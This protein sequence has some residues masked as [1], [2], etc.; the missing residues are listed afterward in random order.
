M[1]KQI[2]LSLILL[3]TIGCQEVLGSWQ[4][5][6][7]IG[8]FM[9]P[10][11]MVY[12]RAP[13]VEFDLAYQGFDINKNQV[14]LSSLVFGKPVVQ[15]KDVFL[16]SNLAAQPGITNAN[17]NEYLS[18]LSTMTIDMSLE[19]KA[20]I[21]DVEASLTFALG[22]SDVL[23]TMG[24]TAPVEYYEQDITTKYLSGG[25]L[26]LASAETIA[27]PTNPGFF[28]AND[29]NM[30]TFFQQN[31]LAPKGLT[32]PA[33]QQSLGIG[34]VR[35]YAMLDFSNYWPE[36]VEKLQGGFV[37]HINPL[38]RVNPNV[39]WPIERGLGATYL[40]GFAQCSLNVTPFLKPF[41]V[42]EVTDDFSHD[43]LMRVPMQ[44]SVTNAQIVA[45]GALTFPA[46]GVLASANFATYD[47]LAPFTQF[48][49]T[50]PFFAD[51]TLLVSRRRGS[52]GQVM[53]GNRFEFGDA[54]ELAIWYEHDHKTNDHIKRSTGNNANTATASNVYNFVP[55][56]QNSRASYQVIGWCIQYTLDN[57]IKF[58]LGSKH[59]VKGK[60]AFQYQ[61]GF[62]KAEFEF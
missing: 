52:W 16:A 43:Q 8:V 22:K 49:T 39:V 37:A 24:I 36:V 5:M 10:T 40:G 41:I 12:V 14:S 9:D 13:Y 15:L 51:T 29:A 59:V 35:V 23:F 28:A 19:Q 42:G 30:D 46:A 48:D 47:V 45:A 60:N 2:K 3:G 53:I 18:L 6:P 58:T 21:F 32:M 61:T 31:V 38:Q 56:T 26:G 57:D 11:K 1:K 50:V 62:A 33:R 27:G 4:P 54:A 44:K 55:L 25:G 34:E 20:C 17:A 7:R